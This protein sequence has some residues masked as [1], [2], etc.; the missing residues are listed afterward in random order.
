MLA[1]PAITVALLSFLPL[2]QTAKLTLLVGCAAPSA[3]AAAMFAQMYGTD[4]LFS[5]RAVALTT[6]LSLV[7]LP[8]V[9]ALMSFLMEVI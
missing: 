6:I 7:T 1:I 2:D 8:G 3:I 4:Y 5:T 9:I